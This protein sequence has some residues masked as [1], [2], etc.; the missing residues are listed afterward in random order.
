MDK[1]SQPGQPKII[2]LHGYLLNF[3]V[4]EVLLYP[5]L[6]E[7]ILGDGVVRRGVNLMASR[8]GKE[9]LYSLQKCNLSRRARARFPLTTLNFCNVLK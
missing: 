8:A 6:P 7:P 5:C 9:N 3:R 4:A 1:E 2:F